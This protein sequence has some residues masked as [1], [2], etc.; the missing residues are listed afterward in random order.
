MK[1]EV[2]D[3]L[4]DVDVNSRID[5]SIIIQVITIIDTIIKFERII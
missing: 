1:L 5:E 2:L 4:Y 3:V